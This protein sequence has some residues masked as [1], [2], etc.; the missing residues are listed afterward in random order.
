MK[1][2]KNLFSRF[3]SILPHRKSSVGHVPWQSSTG[4][5]LIETIIYSALI[6]MI[7]GGSFGVVYQV[8]RGTD[9]LMG[10][11]VRE[12]ELS[13]IF[14]KI[15]WSL[16]NIESIA[17]PAQNSTSSVLILNKRDFAKNPIVF[18]FSSS[19]VYLKLGSDE[20]LPLNNSR[21]LIE[22]LVFGRESFST[23]TAEVMKAKVSVKGQDYETYFHLKQ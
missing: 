14:G 13:F 9:W 21:V 23:S 8:L 10:E 15:N 22:S 5:T 12:Q 3:L 6:A 19:S 2:V 20:S 1:I 16:V 17:S 7:L 18:S 11:I 4:L